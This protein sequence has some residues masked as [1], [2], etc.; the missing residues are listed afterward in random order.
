M[1]ILRRR[2]PKSLQFSLQISRIVDFFE[3]FSQ[4]VYKTAEMK[5]FLQ[6]FAPPRR[7][8]GSPLQ[9]FRAP[10]ILPRCNIFARRLY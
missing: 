4:K 3:D 2:V 6:T 7:Q 5:T 8:E 1:L 9:H 10:Y